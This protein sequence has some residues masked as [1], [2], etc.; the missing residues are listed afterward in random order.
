MVYLHL[1][2]Y[3]VILCLHLSSGVNFPTYPLHIIIIFN[4]AV[5]QAIHM[6]KHVGSG[7]LTK[8]AYQ[9]GDKFWMCN[10]CNRVYENCP[11]HR[12]ERRDHR[13]PQ[14]MAEK[15]TGDTIWFYLNSIMLPDRQPEP[16]KSILLLKVQ[17][18]TMNQHCIQPLHTCILS[19]KY[20]IT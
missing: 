1:C 9:C 16:Q 19:L 10:F 13:Y 6:C 8:I 7:E 18:C 15:I 17:Y 11:F 12:R 3:T 2:V 20:N 4:V 14:Q 5:L